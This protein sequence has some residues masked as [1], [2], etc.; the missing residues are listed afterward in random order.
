MRI[1]PNSKLW[2]SLLLLLSLALSACQDVIDV[3]LQSEPPRLVV[4]GIIERKAGER[5]SAFQ[6]IKLTKSIEFFAGVRPP[7][8]RDAQVSVISSTGEETRFM[9]SERDSAFITNNLAV[10]ENVGYKLRIRYNSDVYETAFDSARRGGTLDSV[11]A[12]P[13]RTTPFDTT[14]GF[15]IAAD[16][17][18]PADVTNFYFIK[19]FKN[20][21]DALEIRPGN[22]FATIRA[23]R[24]FNGETLRGLEPQANIVFQPGDTALVKVISIGESLFEYLRALFIQTQGGGGGTFNP[25]PA[26]VRSNVINLINSERFP[27][28]YFGVGWTSQRTLIVP[29]MPEA[30]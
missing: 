4:E 24:F 14:R 2:F 28:G 18:D 22:Q 7:L 16:F 23:D 5:D 3:A 19:L 10:Q 25:P 30:R 17:T 27:L 20:G 26:P 29:E 11:Y 6:R 13:R 12:R 1:K 8:V 21:R 9:F 15:T